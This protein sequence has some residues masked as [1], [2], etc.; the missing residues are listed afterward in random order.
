[1]NEKHYLS[2]EKPK[3]LDYLKLRK[4]CGFGE[5][6][7]EQSK[8]S[9]SNSLF[10]VSILYSNKLVGFGRVVGD[11]TLFFYIS[12][13]LVSPE[14]AGKGIG[15]M[16]MKE[17]VSYLQKKANSLSTIAVIAFRD[18][19]SFY[20]KYGFELCPNEHFGAGLIYPLL[21]NQRTSIQIDKSQHTNNPMG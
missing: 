13:V 8:E 12:D 3:P 5:V 2:L 11:G 16:L 20:Q 19:E 18:K 9:L 15:G 6:T 4:S 14:M 17:I 10:F 21:F 7:M 1:M